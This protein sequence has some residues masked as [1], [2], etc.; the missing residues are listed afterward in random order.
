MHLRGKACRFELLDEHGASTVLLDVPR[1]DFNWQLPYRYAQPKLLRK[2]C[3]LKFTAWFELIRALM[4][5]T[6]LSTRSL[7]KRL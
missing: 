1:Y 6:M 7:S 4:F 3:T 5:K 2:G